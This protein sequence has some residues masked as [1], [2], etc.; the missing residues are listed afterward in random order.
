MLEIEEAHRL[1]PG[2]SENDRL[3]LEILRRTDLPRA[4]LEAEALAALPG[5]SAGVL[6]E[7]VN[8]LATHADNLPEDRFPPVAERILDW[9]DRFQPPGREPRSR[10]A[11]RTAPLQQGSDPA[12]TGTDRRGPPHARTGPGHRPDHPRD[13][14]ASQWT[15]YDQRRARSPPACDPGRL[16][17]EHR[18]LTPL[19]PP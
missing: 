4:G 17:R 7:C 12:P 3:F 15:S 10:L 11:A 19:L 5:V 2:N 1:C 18:L 8:V 14:E 9:A 16:P 6:A 13:H